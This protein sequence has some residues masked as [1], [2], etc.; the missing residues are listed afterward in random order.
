MS[1]TFPRGF[2]NLFSIIL[3][4]SCIKLNCYT[5]FYSW[6]TSVLLYYTIL[7]LNLKDWT[8]I[9]DHPI[10][11]T[12][13]IFQSFLHITKFEFSKFPLKT[14]AVRINLLSLRRKKRTHSIRRSL[15]MVI[16][17]DK[18]KAMAH[19]EEGILTVMLSLHR[20]AVIVR[21]SIISKPHASFCIFPFPKT[22]R[23]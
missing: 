19:L 1:V 5:L 12:N 14:A 13:N 10:V 3:Y 16:A 17:V 18:W 2:C 11:L 22:L 23:Q 21:L 4:I 9:L 8:C 15:W 7:S 20:Y 6:R